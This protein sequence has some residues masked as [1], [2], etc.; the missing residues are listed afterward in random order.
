[1]IDGRQVLTVCGHAQMIVGFVAD[2]GIPAA[3]RRNLKRG[4]DGDPDSEMIDLH[5]RGFER[6]LP[7]PEVE[8]IGLAG[9]R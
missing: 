5:A 1:M 6:D 7:P 9:L 8:D 3:V 2:A 4:D